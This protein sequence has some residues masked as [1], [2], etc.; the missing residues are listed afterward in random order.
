MGGKNGIVWTIRHGGF[1]ERIQVST[2]LRDIEEIVESCRE[3][4][5]CPYFKAQF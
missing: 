1:D 2:A 5:V 3:A 4:T